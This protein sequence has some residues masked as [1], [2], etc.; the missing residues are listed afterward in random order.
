MMRVV[1]LLEKNQTQNAQI[2]DGLKKVR[3]EI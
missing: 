3:G 2:I 1:G